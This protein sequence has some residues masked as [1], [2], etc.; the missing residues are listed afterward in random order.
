[1]HT[2][3][4]TSRKL[5]YVDSR[6]GP[7]STLWVLDGFGYISFFFFFWGGGLN[8]VHYVQGLFVDIF[9]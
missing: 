6:N 5:R 9:H 3:S 7:G 8:G 2:T 4:D 1:M